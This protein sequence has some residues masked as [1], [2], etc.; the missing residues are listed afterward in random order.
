MELAHSV[1]SIRSTVGVLTL[2]APPPPVQ[3][4]IPEFRV[5][6]SSDLKPSG[7]PAVKGSIL[8]VQIL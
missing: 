6:Q 2:S 5:C 3:G 4:L 8:G 7:A 1:S